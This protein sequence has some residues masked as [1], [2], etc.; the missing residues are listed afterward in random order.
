MVKINKQ[1]ISLLPIFFKKIMAYQNTIKTASRTTSNIID[2]LKKLPE[3]IEA[4]TMR[5]RPLISEEYILSSRIAPDMF[6]LKMQIG[7]MS[8]NLKGAVSRL[9][10]IDAPK[11]PDTETTISELIERLEKTLEFVNSVSAESYEGADTRNV[12]LPFMP[13]KQM[14]MEVYI[15][16]YFVPNFYFHATTTYNILRALGLKIGKGNYIGNVEM[17]DIG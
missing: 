16:D 12:I 6:P 10:N 3:F 5:G 7:I 11:M 13:T 17:T 9:T 1:Q 2:I 8:D 15:N 4:N 14:T